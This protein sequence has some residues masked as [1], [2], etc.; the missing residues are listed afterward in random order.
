[1]LS[2]KVTIMVNAARINPAKEIEVFTISDI[3][4]FAESNVMLNERTLKTSMTVII[5]AH[6]KRS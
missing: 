2:L 5:N 6:I 3:V 4:D 1:M